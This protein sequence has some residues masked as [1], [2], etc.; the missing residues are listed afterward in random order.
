L[1]S[2]KTH[3]VYAVLLLA[4]GYEEVRAVLERADEVARGFGLETYFPGG[5]PHMS[6]GVGEHKGIAANPLA[7]DMDRWPV[8]SLAVTV[9]SLSLS[10]GKKTQSVQLTPL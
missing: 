2:P 7:T 10:K 1:E 4:A 3:L 5:T 6:L 9:T 8:K